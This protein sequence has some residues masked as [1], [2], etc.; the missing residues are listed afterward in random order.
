MIKVLLFILF[1]ISLNAYD[2]A[3][4]KNIK[5]IKTKELNY[6]IDGYKLSEISDLVYD[7]NS[8]ILYMVSDKGVLFS[9]RAKFTKDNFK[10]K[11]LHAYPLRDKNG[12]NLEDGLK[13][14]EGMALDSRGNLY[15]SFERINKIYQVSKMGRLIKEIKLPKNLEDIIPSSS[16]KSF[17]SLAWHKKYGFISALEY[18]KEGLNRINQTI[19]SLSGKEW[20]FKMEN[21]KRN[22]ISEVEVMDDGNLLVLERAFNWFIGEFEVN[23]VKVYIN[24]CKEKFCK[25]E[26]I[27][28]LKLNR[29]FNLENYEGLANIGNGRYLL[30]SDDNNN[31]L[32]LT[33]LIYFRVK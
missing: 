26:L 4:N 14:S 30:I 32:A 18:P 15:I 9:F 24:D 17:E 12:K 8:S 33:K 3:F 28:K 29:F 20:N 19:Y 22:G 6:K 10:L 31:F 1:F 13:D 27:L 11:P 5:I 25:K 2:I 21:I 16:N 7:K 23:L